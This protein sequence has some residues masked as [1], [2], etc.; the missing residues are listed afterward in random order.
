MY[1]SEEDVQGEVISSEGLVLTNHH[2]GYGA[3]QQHSNVE[4]DYLTDG[5]WAMNRD[6]ELPTPGLTVTFIDRILDVTDYVNEQLKKIRTRMVLI[7]YLQVI[8]AT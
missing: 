5:F 8:L 4:H 7:I 2:C 3:I 6:A 1:T